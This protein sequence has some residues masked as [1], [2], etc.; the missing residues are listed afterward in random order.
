M[1]SYKMFGFTVF[2]VFNYVKRYIVFYD[3]VFV[4]VS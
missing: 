2:L 3:F 1:A 4:Q